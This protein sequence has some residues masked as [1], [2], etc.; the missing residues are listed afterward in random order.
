MKILEIMHDAKI[1]LVD[2]N[3]NLGDKKNALKLC[4]QYK[5]KHYF[6]QYRS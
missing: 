4:V 6:F 3:I 2:L 1:I 5:K